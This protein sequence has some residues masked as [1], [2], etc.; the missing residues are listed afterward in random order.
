MANLIRKNAVTQMQTAIETGKKDGMSTFDQHLRALVQAKLITPY[1][2][3]Q[4]STNPAA[5]S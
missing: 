1:E 4:N 5:F 2:A 3:A